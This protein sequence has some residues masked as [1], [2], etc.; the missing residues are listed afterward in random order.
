VGLAHACRNVARKE[1]TQKSIAFYL[2]EV[3]KDLLGDNVG[4]PLK[5]FRL[6]VA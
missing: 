1:M 3:F 2:Q 6:M 5:P 4:H